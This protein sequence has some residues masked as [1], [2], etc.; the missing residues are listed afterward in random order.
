MDVGTVRPAIASV[1]GAVAV[2][3][4]QVEALDAASGNLADIY[5]GLDTATNEPGPVD[6]FVV[7]LVSSHHVDRLVVLDSDRATVDTEN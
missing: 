2:S 7:D 4:D 1:H 5:G 3:G 6:A